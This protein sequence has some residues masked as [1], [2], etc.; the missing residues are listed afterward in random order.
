M[1]IMQALDNMLG[2]IV[3]QPLHVTLAADADCASRVDCKLSAVVVG[4]GQEL[5]GARPNSGSYGLQCYRA[6]SYH[7]IWQGLK[8]IT[9]STAKD[10]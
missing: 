5:E 1:T 7:N 6:S 4:G 9:D 8:H 2:F 10:D 3:K